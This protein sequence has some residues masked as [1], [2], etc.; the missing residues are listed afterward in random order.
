VTLIAALADTLQ[1][2]RGAGADCAT[3]SHEGSALNW[4]S[5]PLHDRV[6]LTTNETRTIARLEQV[7]TVEGRTAP[8]HGRELCVAL[9]MRT[10]VLDAWMTFRPWAVWLLPVTTV[11]LV[12]TLSSSVLVAGLFTA[13]WAI[14]L[15]A[16][17]T[18]SHARFNAKRRARRTEHEAEG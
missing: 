3:R 14:G 15:G 13:A 7:L 10:R 18:E 16:L 4:D 8:R 6:E 17:I 9:N 1:G 5:E 11:G 12:L 2:T